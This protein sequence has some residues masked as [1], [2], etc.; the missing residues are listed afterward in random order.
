MTAMIDTQQFDKMMK[1]YAN[2]FEKKPSSAHQ[3][4]Q[5][6]KD[7]NYSFKYKQLNVHLSIWLKQQTQTG[8]AQSNTKT[9]TK[10]PAHKQS[11]EVVD[12]DR[13]WDEYQ[14]KYGYSPKNARKFLSFIKEGKKIIIKFKAARDAFTRISK[15]RIVS[16]VEGGA[17]SDTETYFILKKQGNDNETILKLKIDKNTSTEQLEQIKTKFIELL[18]CFRAII[19]DDPRSPL[20]FYNFINDR[21]KYKVSHG[22]V[23][24]VYKYALEQEW[25]EPMKRVYKNKKNKRVYKEQSD[26]GSDCHSDEGDAEFELVP[27]AE[28]KKTSKKKKKCKKVIHDVMT[29]KD[30]DAI[31]SQYAKEYENKP[32]N[33]AQIQKF[34]KEIGQNYKWRAVRIAFARWTDF[35][36]AKMPCEE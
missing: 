26:E 25:F 11:K 31:L 19:C 12:F 27:A 36:G 34:G 8:T 5:F 13:F 14:T 6:C 30:L 33:A 22:D 10:T 29:D 7:R 9:D 24:Y 16:E 20:H 18:Q 35:R 21:T 1:E 3:L 15:E 2:S 17:T 32:T 28:K 4:V 23:Q